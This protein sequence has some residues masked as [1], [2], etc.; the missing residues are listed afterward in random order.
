[1][2]KEEVKLCLFK[3]NMIGFEKNLLGFLFLFLFF[4]FLGPHL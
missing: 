4:V 1:M 2:E 3:D